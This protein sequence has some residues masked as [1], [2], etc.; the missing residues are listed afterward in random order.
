VRSCGPWAALCCALLCLGLLCCVVLCCVVDKRYTGRIVVV[1][2]AGPGQMPCAVVAPCLYGVTCICC[3]VDV[4]V[5]AASVYLLLG[6]SYAVLCWLCCSQCRCSG[7]KQ[8]L[9]GRK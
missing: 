1:C 4:Q 9:P 8:P 3:A 7:Y 5:T 2:S 6:L